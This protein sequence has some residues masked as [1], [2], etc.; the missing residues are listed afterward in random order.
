MIDNAGDNNLAT[1]CPLS[2]IP[3]VK[4]VLSPNVNVNQVWREL[5]KYDLVNVIESVKNRLLDFLLE[6]DKEMNLDANFIPSNND[7]KTQRIFNNTI[8]ASI[9]NFG[10]NSI[11]EIKD[12]NIAVNACSREVLDEL[13]DIVQAIEKDKDSNNEDIKELLSDIKEEIKGGKKNPN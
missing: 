3:L 11:N 4:R 6:F 2:V 10:S 12:C 13:I 8:N 1:P 9:A 7:M 5:Q